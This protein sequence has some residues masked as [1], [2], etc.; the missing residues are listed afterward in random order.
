MMI[1]ILRNPVIRPSLPLVLD[2]S[3]LLFLLIFFF[4]EEKVSL[5][6]LIAD[7]VL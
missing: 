7:I 1:F 6:Y 2:N 4:F 3:P 5:N